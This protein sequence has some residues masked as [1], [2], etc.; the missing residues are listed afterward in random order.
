MRFDS[1]P[2]EVGE[3]ACNKERF[4]IASP[5][6][7][8]LIMRAHCTLKALSIGF[9][10]TAAQLALRREMFC[11]DYDTSAITVASRLTRSGLPSS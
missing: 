5:V 4:R 7:P 3:K 6:S 2:V 10:L 9:L 8:F 1:A 11:I